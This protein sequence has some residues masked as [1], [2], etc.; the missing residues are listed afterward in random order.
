[1]KFAAQTNFDFSPYAN[2]WRPEQKEHPFA[3]LDAMGFV[4]ER[5]QRMPMWLFVA[6]GF[7]VISRQPVEVLI[8]KEEDVVVAQCV[9][10]HVFASGDSRDE[11]I[12]SLS[13]QVVHFFREYSGLDANELT[14]QAAEI[15]RLYR[16]NFEYSKP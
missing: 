11:A 3:Y 15:Q 10:L 16:D 2:L 13:E 8:S 12:E 9:R 6:D 14:E 4:A 7:R 1:M 5:E